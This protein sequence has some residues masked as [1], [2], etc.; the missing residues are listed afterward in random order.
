MKFQIKLQ[1]MKNVD[2]K[3][4]FRYSFSW[5]ILNSHIFKNANCRFPSYLD[6]ITYHRWTIEAGGYRWHVLD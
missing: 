1:I 6:A 5:K 3:G 2:S 4:I